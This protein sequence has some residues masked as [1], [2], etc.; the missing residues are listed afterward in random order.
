ME[1]IDE[2]LEKRVWQRVCGN[3]NSPNIPG[4]SAAEQ[5]LSAVYFALSRMAQ[6]NQKN[7]LRQLYQK[8]RSHSRCLWG[9]SRLQDGPKGRKEAPL[10][11]ID[12]PE[13]ALRKCYALT[14]KA[15]QAYS[16]LESAPE[17]GHIFQALYREEVENCR[18]LLELLGQ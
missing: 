3:Q 17:Y 16:Q 2:K 10:P 11:V 14:L 8:E 1:K 7:L 12:R 5:D 4:L 13:T 9:I 6:G 18:L 15:M